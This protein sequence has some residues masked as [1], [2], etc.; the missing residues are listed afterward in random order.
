MNYGNIEEEI[1]EYHI[2]LK[3]S[4]ITIGKLS[5]LFKE[6]GKNGMRFLEKSQK[7]FEDFFTELK[8]EDNTTTLNI[9][10][11]NIYNE[12]ISFFET[13]KN[14]FNSLDKRIG[15]KLSEFENDYKIKN[16]D[17]ILKF[18]KLNIKLNESKK[19]LD[20]IK[21]NYFDSAKDI[22]EFEKKVDPKKMTDDELMKWTQK[23]IKV[24]EISEERK[25]IYQKEVKNFNN[26]LE[27]S[28]IEYI[29]IKACFKNDQNDKI[30]FYIDIITRLNSIIKELG[31]SL[32]NT[33]KIMNKSKEDINI[34]RDLKLFENDFNHLDN[35][36]KKRFVQ[37]HFLNYELRNKNNVKTGK[38]ID[39]KDKVEEDISSQDSKYMK[40]LQI[41]ELGNDDFL[42]ISSLNQSDLL[43]DKMISE[44][45]N[46]ESKVSDEVMTKILMYYKN[47]V[48]NIKRFIY[49]LVNHFCIK[50][51]VNINYID[52]FY[53]LNTIL[54]E[55]I[56]YCFQKKEIF[57]LI[58]L[59]MFISNKTV[60]LDK[61]TNTIKYYLC[62][63]MKKNI[64]FNN[65]DFWLELL[66]K[67]VELI[68]E[69]EITREMINRKDIIVDKGDSTKGTIG[70]F[71]GRGNYN[72]ALEKE[73][74]FN[75]I[76]QKK[77]PI[78]C[79]KV[80]E[81]YIKEFN[82]YNFYGNDAIK[83]IE[84]LA[85]KYKLPKVNK[86]YYK[87]VMETNNFIKNKVISSKN[88]SIENGKYEKYYFNFKKNKKF[89]GINE[90]NI[91][92]IIFA[93]RFLDVKEFP[94]ILCLNK[95]LN[96][97]IIKI[98]YKNILFKYCDKLDIKTHLS[99]WKV[100]LNYTEVKK[101]YKYK[102][103]LEEVKKNPDSVES[104]DIIQLDIIRTSFF[105]DEEIKREKIGNMLKAIAKEL[106]SLNYCQGMN[107]IAS[108][109]LDICDY[110][111][112]EA[113]YMFLSLLIDTDY[114]NL[115]K[116]EL[117]KLNLLFYQFERILSNSLPEIYFYLRNN[118]ITPGYFVSPWFI[119]IF[120]DAFLD[121]P[122]LNNN[123]IIMKV[124]DLFI[125]GGWKAIIKI[126][127]SLLK[128]N[129]FKIL[130]TPNE[131][132]LNYLTNDIIKSKYF[133]KDNIY[134]IM[135]ASIK[136]KINGKMLEETEKQY[137]FLKALPPL[138]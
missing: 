26:F 63:E 83:L 16:K 108:F 8:K 102:N 27:Q 117:E 41:L 84:K 37:E 68:A 134:E 138:E 25:N 5:I 112:E 123:K 50:E 85:I 20:I 42:D 93:L 126:G 135:N 66:S 17:N 21:N 104:I 88:I 69:V 137:Y 47:N 86:E 48:T 71:F 105:S 111:E 4:E 57:D 58:F 118:N 130:N 29:S 92:G 95:D 19:Q 87:K 6:F 7:S 13:L 122:E 59:I 43:L 28:E 24:K 109:F 49:I 79:N 46:K 113:F 127:M 15:D 1:K 82:N 125:L 121:K 74:L 9:S 67:R 99:I 132:L 33:Q 106:P 73:I 97:K 45:L 61:N 2:F 98:I 103:I 65:I 54:S 64:I 114:S 133:G 51:F 120:T 23:K 80:I 30:L 78:F 107:H 18:N 60:Y 31:E 101:K 14:C 53:Y 35:T 39:N 32:S 94:K 11:N 128:Y 22:M 90:Q 75:Q 55:I 115:F 77:T 72:K 110:D 3:Q 89:K 44:L 91:I 136:F 81:E 34:R 96:K 116:N 38:N 36:T 10:L 62:N 12:Y 70:K 124:F 52:N 129:E 76:F 56:N 100:S 40:A 119:T 131:E